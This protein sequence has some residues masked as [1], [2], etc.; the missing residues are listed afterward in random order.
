M[1][2][3]GSSRHLTG[4]RWIGDSLLVAAAIG[5]VYSALAPNLLWGGDS[6]AYI[7]AVSTGEIDRSVHFL[8][9]P[10]MRWAA[11]LGAVFGFDA[12]LSLRAASSWAT[13]LGVGVLH[14]A[15]VLMGASRSRAVSV[16]VMLAVTPAVAFFGMIVEIPGVL[17]GATALVWLAA[18]MF[19]RKPQALTAAAM[20]LAT[21]VAGS[22]HSSAHLMPLA[23]A[24]FCFVHTHL[25][26]KRLLCF[27]AILGVAHVAWLVLL[28]VATDLLVLQ[29][30]Q[31]SV[32]LVELARE[33]RVELGT[34]TSHTLHEWIIPYAPLSFVILG[35]LRQVQH[36]RELMALAVS[37]LAYGVMAWPLLA[38]TWSSQLV[39]HGGYYLALAFPLAWLG[40]AQY[41]LGVGKW[42]W[43]GG[44]ILSATLLWGETL[45]E[46]SAVIP[47]EMRSALG[48]EEA[49]LLCH[50]SE[51]LLEVCRTLP[52]MVIYKADQVPGMA[53]RREAIYISFD[54]LYDSGQRSG[55]DVFLTDAL[56]NAMEQ[57]SIPLGVYIRKNYATEVLRAGGFVAHRVTRRPGG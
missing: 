15:A 46:T 1:T 30:L 40:S 13:A 47:A 10:F 29:S 32:A 11:D 52:S 16:A 21:G 23:V 35:A 56:K 17:F 45:K 27:G 49:T 44:A 48:T 38:A 37:L 18:A 33:L 51:D 19:V 54:R 4:P 57:A 22:I 28:M 42:L 26:M 14:Q 50:S 41:S 43:T 39:E 7:R 24:A 9:L 2:E 3:D 31:D 53:A 5:L 6:L 20:G 12:Y 8:Y 25:G 34:T 36:R 55:R